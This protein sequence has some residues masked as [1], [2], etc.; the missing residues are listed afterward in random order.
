MKTPIYCLAAGFSS[1]VVLTA[2]T[3][4]T[5]WDFLSGRDRVR[6]KQIVEAFTKMLTEAKPTKG[7]I[8]VCAH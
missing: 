4:V 8:N 1:K 6:T 5:Y 7:R 3:E 2:P